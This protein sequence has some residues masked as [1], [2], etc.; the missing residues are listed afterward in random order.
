M[1][2]AFGLLLCVSACSSGGSSGSGGAAGSGGSG[3]AGAAGTAGTAGA[4]TGGTSATGGSAG[5]GGDDAGGD[6]AAAKPVVEIETS[7]G[8]MAIE[9]EPDKMPITTANFLSY[10][11]DGFF[12]GTIIHRVIPDFVIQGGGY[13]AGLVPK[14]TKPPI[15][16][17]THPD[18]KHVYGAIS[19]ARTTDPNSATSQFFIVNAPGGASNLDD[20]Y[21]AF[22]NLIEGGAVLD[23]ISGVATETQGTFDDV[24]V[25]DIV[26]TSAKRR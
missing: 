10:V 19:M 23:A 5:Q 11:D 12:A 17:E 24:P 22:G 18:L 8:M 14:A 3:A 13:E 20:Q 25:Q 4:G 7:M 9:L 1:R 21:A 15:V 2:W 6:S 26:V 16:L